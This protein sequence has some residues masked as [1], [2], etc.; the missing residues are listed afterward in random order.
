MRNRTGNGGLDRDPPLFSSST[1][2]DD[3]GEPTH[4]DLAAGGATEG[5]ALD[6]T[7]LLGACII[8]LSGLFLCVSLFGLVG[9]KLL[10]RGDEDEEHA[11]DGDAGGAAREGAELS[12]LQ[13]WARDWHAPLFLPLSLVTL[14]V[15]VYARW[16]SFKFF[17]TN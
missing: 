3:A 13:W 10:L 5:D 12:F 11:V 15:W 16:L 1:D 17:A 2:E 9:A 14:A 4:A 7:P 8:V 6:R